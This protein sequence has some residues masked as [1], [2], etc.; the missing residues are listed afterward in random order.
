MNI[1]AHSYIAGEVADGVLSLVLDPFVLVPLHMSSWGLFY[2][3]M[4]SL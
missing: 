2:P 3:E 1:W 4:S